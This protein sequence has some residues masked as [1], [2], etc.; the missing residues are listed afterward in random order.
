MMLLDCGV[1]N[2]NDASTNKNCEWSGK[3]HQHLDI[4]H[5]CLKKIR[6]FILCWLSGWPTTS[7]S[8]HPSFLVSDF[9]LAIMAWGAKL[10]KIYDTIIKMSECKKWCDESAKIRLRIHSTLAICFAHRNLSISI[11]GIGANKHSHPHI[12]WKMH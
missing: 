10:N 1:H 4:Q 12:H 11:C 5:F 7:I 3:I 8:S 2:G 9:G 6:C